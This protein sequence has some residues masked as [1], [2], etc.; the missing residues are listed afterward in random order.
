MVWSKIMILEE[1]PAFQQSEDQSGEEPGARR[2]QKHKYATGSEQLLDPLDRLAEVLRGVQ[3]I[4]CDRS[5]PARRLRLLR[6]A[7]SSLAKLPSRTESLRL[8]RQDAIDSRMIVRSRQVR[9]VSRPKFRV[10]PARS[11]RSSGRPDR[12]RAP[13][14]QT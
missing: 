5:P 6:P 14:P 12:N 13:C 9:R 11:A 8:A 4:G 3:H 7:G 2:L 1:P 10:R